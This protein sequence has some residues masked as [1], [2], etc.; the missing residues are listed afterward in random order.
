MLAGTCT[1]TELHS[2]LWA[3]FL[4]LS[5]L[6]QAELVTVAATE[7]EQWDKW[8]QGQWLQ[9]MSEKLQGTRD[10]YQELQT[11]VIGG[12]PRGCQDSGAEG[13]DTQDPRVL[14]PKASSEAEIPADA[15]LSCY[16]PCGCN[17]WGKGVYNS[18]TWV[19]G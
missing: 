17:C 2:W 5:L 12:V 11:P 7:W 16:C 13:P 4:P 10:R 6:E 9:G 1:A 19:V 8:F 3:H 14:T 18:T 15:A